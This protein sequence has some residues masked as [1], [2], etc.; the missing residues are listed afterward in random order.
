MSRLR[1]LLLHWL[2]PLLTLCLML[3]IALGYRLTG[4][5]PAAAAALAGLAAVLLHRGLHR[6]ACL[7]GLMLAVGALLG[8][9][10]VHPML[11]AEGDYVV[12]G[13][14]ADRV[15]RRGDGQIHTDLRHLTLNGQPLLHGAYWSFYA[16]EVPEGLTPGAHVSFTASLYHPGGADNPGGYDFRAALLQRDVHVGLYGGRDT[17]R[18][19]RETTCLWGVTASL[20]DR[21]S[22]MLADRLGARGG[23][24]AS[25]MLLGERSLM[26]DDDR[27]AFQRMGIAHVLSVSGYHVGVLCALLLWL[28][29]RLRLPLRWQLLPVCLLLT[30]YCLLTGCRAPVIR[31]SLLVVLA[32]IGRRV[33]A[34]RARLHWL[35]GSAMVQLVLSPIQLSSASF[36][37]TYTAL[38]GITLCTPFLQRCAARIRLWGRLT[39][40][41]SLVIGAQ[42]GLLL[43]Q[44]YWFHTLPLMGLI[45]NIPLTALATLLITL[46]WICLPLLPIPAVG[47]ALGTAAGWISELFADCIRFMSE[48]AGW[49]LWTRQSNLLTLLGWLALLAAL[50]LIWQHRR[51]SQLLLAVTG[52]LVLALSVTPWPHRGVT[53]TQLS[54]GDADAAVLQDDTTV[55]VIDTGEGATLST[56][57]HQRRMSVDTLILTHLHNDHTGGLAALLEAGIPIRTCLIGEG[58]RSQLVDAWSIQLLEQ[59]ALSGTELREIARGDVL[60]LPHGQL[61]VLWPDGGHVRSGQDA[62]H[63]SLALLAQLYDTRLLLTGDLTGRYES[64]A[65]VPADVLKAAHHGS[66]ASTGDAFLTAVQPQLVLQSCAKEARAAALEPRLDGIPLYATART[67]AVTLSIHEDG[68]TVSAYHDAP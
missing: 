6:R 35:S 33:G 32:L 49:M 61:T 66:A 41:I 8:Y 60:P 34:S 40:A 44:L 17:L 36:Q 65:A 3:G 68:L 29:R 7:L 19:D 20:R 1:P 16:D 11:P 12:S 27:T 2:L 59:L 23:A 62:N 47:P 22:A 46:Y 5:L 14:V 63:Y 24:F 51:R 15:V 9:A 64:Y 67:G 45:A 58:A 21:L 26:A 43:P 55:V 30:G 48:H 39:D 13:V 4:I 18:C 54:V 37:L 52:M 42:L 53:Y 31:A 56:Y 50:N 38:L 25:A 28:L 57:L 10:S